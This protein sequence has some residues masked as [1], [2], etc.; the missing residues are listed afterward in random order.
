MHTYAKPV[1]QRSQCCELLFPHMCRAFLTEKEKEERK[2]QRALAKAERQLAKHQQREEK[3][4]LKVAEREARSIVKA[5]SP[6]KA[7]KM[8]SEDLQV[9]RSLSLTAVPYPPVHLILAFGYLTC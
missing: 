3:E 8:P 7:S 4:L 5:A 9:C 1:L 2:L 6:R